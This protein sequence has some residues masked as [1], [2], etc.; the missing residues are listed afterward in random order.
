MTSDTLHPNTGRPAPVNAAKVHKT[1]AAPNAR[2]FHSRLLGG[3]FLAGYLTYG[4]GFGLVT[5]VTN[6]PDLLAALPAHQITLMLGAFLMLL[7]TGV[8]IGKAVLFFPVIERHG[9]RTAL[10]YLATMI[11][12]VVL[13]DIGVF[14][15]LSLVPLAQHAAGTPW[16]DATSSLAI[17]ANATAY[18]VAEMT[19]AIGCIFLCALLYRTRLIPRFLSIAGLIGYP[20]LMAGTIA[21]LFGL[22]IGTMLTIPGMFF[23]L[24]LPFWLFIKGFE[25]AAYGD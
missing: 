16:A 8:D 21:E 12:E 3:L 20:I 1:K 15:L 18:Q 23:E 4:V 5:S 24:V 22:H 19:L 9:K 2:M 13:L 25:P 10:V 6:T 11:V 14:A 7:N 17:T